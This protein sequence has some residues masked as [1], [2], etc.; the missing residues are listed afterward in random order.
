MA[1]NNTLELV[2]EVDVNK[3]NPS[4]K[5]VQAVLSSI[6][7][8]RG[9]VDQGVGRRGCEIRGQ[10]RSYEGGHGGLPEY[11]RYLRGG[12]KTVKAEMSLASGPWT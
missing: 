10:H 3:A 8:T 9:L 11:M 6:D 12:L 1:D 4:I 5:G 2:V 7:Q